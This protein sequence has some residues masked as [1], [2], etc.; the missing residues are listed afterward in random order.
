MDFTKLDGLIPAVIQDDVSK[1]VLMVGF[2]SRLR[3]DHDRCRR[4]HTNVYP[5]AGGGPVRRGV[6]ERQTTE[7]S[8]SIRLTLDGKGRYD[9]RTGV[10][11]LDHMASDIRSSCGALRFPCGSR[12]LPLC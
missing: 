2:M 5:G 1:E 9:V 6:I 3:A 12:S 8:I 11:F 10:R 4:A 7:T